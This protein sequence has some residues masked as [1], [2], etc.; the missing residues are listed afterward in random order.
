MRIAGSPTS[1][2]DRGRQ[3]RGQGQGD[4]PG[5]AEVLGEVH[6]GVG[7]DAEEGG[8]AEAHQAR[9]AGQHHERE[10]AEPVDE[11][12]ADVD[13]VLGHQA[14]Q[15]EEADEERSVAVALDAVAEEPEV[16]L[17]RR[18]EDEAHCASDLLP[19]HGPEHALRPHREHEE[20]HHVGGHVLA[21]R[22]A[23]RRPRTAR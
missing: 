23:G 1:T 14:R 13:Q 4:D 7:A 6:V 2:P 8:V 11:D 3:R 19:A 15:D 12:E 18:L 5:Q 10:A 20:Q 16:L 9:V 22:G 21:R 17:V